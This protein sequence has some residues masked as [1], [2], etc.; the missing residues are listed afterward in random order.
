MMRAMELVYYWQRL[1]E[2]QCA[3]S[4]LFCAF[5]V[6]V[7]AAGKSPAPARGLQSACT[8][9]VASHLGTHSG[10]FVSTKFFGS[11]TQAS[12]RLRMTAAKE[13]GGI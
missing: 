5:A 9:D 7:L 4:M 1:L 11:H 6:G 12:R 10:H 13:N 3:A 8:W 2:E